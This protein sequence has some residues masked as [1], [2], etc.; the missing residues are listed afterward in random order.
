[1]SD[2]GREVLAYIEEVTWGTTPA[3]ALTKVAFA[4]SENLL[5]NTTTVV[6]DAI[7]GDYIKPQVI[8]TNAEGG[9]SINFE[10]AYADGPLLD[11]IEGAVRSDW[12]TAGSTPSTSLAADDAANK[13]TRAAG[14]FVTDGWVVGMSGKASGFATAAN[15][16]YFVVTA[17][18]ATNLT[19]SG[20]DLAT[21]A[22]GGNEV[23]TNSGYLKV[24]TTVK[25]YTLEKQFAD[26]TNKFIPM[27]GARVSS[28]SLSA[29]VG[30]IVTGSV[31]FVGKA[32]TA[33]ASATAGSG[34]YSASAGANNTVWNGVDNVTGIFVA[35]DDTAFT[36]AV[37]YNVSQIDLNI[38]C[39]ARPIGTLGTLGPAAIGSN[40]FGIGGSMRV[41]ADD[42]SIALWSDY[43][44]YTEKAI[45][46]R[47]V[48]AGGNAFLIYLPQVQITASEGP[49]SSG[50][51][52]DIMLNLNFTAE[53]DSDTSSLLVI[54]RIAA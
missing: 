28:L 7:R 4:T 44:N 16:G 14:S 17:V 40:S 29:Q 11:F 8:R 51:D 47:F 33:I 30:A 26:L 37:T 2:G 42:T 49:A 36:T 54:S 50:P 41:Y 48:D 3:S 46:Y 39:P 9:G 5:T 20:L 35:N 15:N 43:I 38:N 32:Q 1:M 6:T 18:D 19:V 21:E 52:S 24:G 23:L 34:A 25:S 12:A 45:W 13:Y 10:A 53:Y 31:G 22:A 27:K